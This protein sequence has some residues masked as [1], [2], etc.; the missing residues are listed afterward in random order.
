MMKL[1][2]TTDTITAM[3]LPMAT[4]SVN[5]AVDQSAVEHDGHQCPDR[6]R[7]PHEHRSRTIRRTTI[8]ATQ[9]QY[10]GRKPAA[11]LS[12]LIVFHR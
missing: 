5:D 11:R 4:Q 8:C 2:P 3:P 12:A 10:S 6:Q 9:S 1:S 7:R